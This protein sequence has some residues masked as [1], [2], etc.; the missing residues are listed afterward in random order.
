MFEFLIELGWNQICKSY[1]N[2]KLIIVVELNFFSV[3]II[4]RWRHRWSIYY[5]LQPKVTKT[6]DSL[7]ALEEIQV[8]I[9]LLSANDRETTEIIVIPTTNVWVQMSKWKIL[10]LGW[11]N[12]YVINIQLEHLIKLLEVMLL[13]LKNCITMLPSTNNS[14]MT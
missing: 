6:M 14:V 12:R 4:R 13:W 2:N 8:N 3:H 7:M 5:I 9:G 10:D 11:I 1:N